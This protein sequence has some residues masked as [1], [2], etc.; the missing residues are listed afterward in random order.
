M[1]KGV[2]REQSLGGMVNSVLRISLATL[3][4]IAS[5]GCSFIFTKG[6][7]PEVHPPPECTT[8]VAAPAVDTVMI[9]ASVALV[10]AG[11]ATAASSCTSGFGLNFC[12]LNQG[13]GLGAILLGAVSGVVFTSS[14][15]VGFNR[16]SACRALLEPNALPPP[17]PVVPATSLFPASPTKACAGMG[18]VPHVCARVV[19][20]QGRE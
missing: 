14:A 1:P 18:D 12:G 19:L 15:V 9:A 20:L 4:L 6:P 11:A 2:G 13:V 16:T 8:S 7:E 17:S 10:V 5:P 3:I